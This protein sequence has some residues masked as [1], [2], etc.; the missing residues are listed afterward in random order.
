MAQT[1]ILDPIAPLTFTAV[2]V[3][4]NKINEAKYQQFLE[5]ENNLRTEI[6]RDLE[7]INT[8]V[9]PTDKLILKSHLSSSIQKLKLNHQALIDI[10]AQATPPVHLSMDA[11][12]YNLDHL[13]TAFASRGP[14]ATRYAAPFYAPTALPT[15]LPTATYRNV[16]S[17]PYAAP[18]VALPTALPTEV[19][20]TSGATARP[21]IDIHSSE[22]LATWT[23]VHPLNI[24]LN[25]VNDPRVVGVINWIKYPIKTDKDLA[26]HY[27]RMLSNFPSTEGLSNMDWRPVFDAFVKECPEF[28]FN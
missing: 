24:Y 26:I 20:L 6:N 21:P 5:E 3:F 25:S 18:Y 2:P 8:N 12:K 7:A 16:T 4:T 19:H 15:A 27:H 13:H 22:H 14:I 9:D 11:N 1:V 28:K 17:V 10:C 23:D